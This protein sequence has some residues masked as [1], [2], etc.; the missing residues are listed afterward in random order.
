[1]ISGAFFEFIAVR[2]WKLIDRDAL[3][4]IRAH[5]SPAAI[6]PMADWQILEVGTHRADVREV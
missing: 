1:M 2:Y 3:S 5:F 4:E 6:G